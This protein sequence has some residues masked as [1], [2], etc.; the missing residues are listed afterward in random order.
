V[1]A[2]IALVFIVILFGGLFLY[3]WETGRRCLR[4]LSA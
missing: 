1:Y 3:L 2:N 4:A